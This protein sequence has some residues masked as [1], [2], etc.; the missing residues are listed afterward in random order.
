MGCALVVEDGDDVKQQIVGEILAGS[1]WR[2]MS[3]CDVDAVV[4][5]EESAIDWR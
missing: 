1:G 4:P 3:P 5:C 2:S